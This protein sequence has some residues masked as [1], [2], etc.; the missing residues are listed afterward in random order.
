MTPET[1]LTLSNITRA[2]RAGIPG[3]GASIDVLRDVSLDVHAGELVLIEGAPSSGKTTLLL[4]A[5]GLLRPDSGTV[6]WPACGRRTTQAPKSV[7]YVGDRATTY[8]FL[9]VR[10]SLAYATTLHD[11][12]EPRREPPAHDPLDLAGLRE[13]TG[14]RVAL[15]SRGERARFLVA[16]ALISGP[17]L[18]LVDDLTADCDS[19]ARSDFAACL[20]RVADSGP[21]VLWGARTGFG[22]PR[23]RAYELVR[24]R[25]RDCSGVVRTIDPVLDTPGGQNVRSHPHV[26]HRVAEP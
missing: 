2:Y 4:C 20:S 17:R 25:L 22:T 3:C 26:T 10:E 13:L 19:V 9:T 15:L 11:I 12:D 8:G 14:T 5:A 16:L 24:G 7:R 1:L 18:L 6:Q 23:G 21:A